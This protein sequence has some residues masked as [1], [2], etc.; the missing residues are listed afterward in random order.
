MATLH[1][2]S[3]SPFSDE[4]FASCLRLLGERDGLLLSGDA[5]H[6]LQP[7]TAPRDA[8][9][10]LPASVALLVLED[11]LNAR[12][13]SDRQPARARVIDYP[14]F[15]DACLQYAKVNSWL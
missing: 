6:A 4:R 3:H 12:G 9:E 15:V 1:L 10:R 13:L 14:G 8:L 7:G 5:V 11:D 2:L